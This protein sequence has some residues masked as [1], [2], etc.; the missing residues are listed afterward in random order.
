MK[1]VA[2]FGNVGGGK[3]TLARRLADLTGVPL[4]PVDM[5]QIRPGGEYV[6]HEEYL[7]VHADI[8][9]RDSWIIE[10]YGDSASAWQRF[11]AADTL[12][13]I[14]L[15]VALHVWWAT[16]RFFK[17]IL[18][19]PEGWPENSPMWRFTQMSY[20]VIGR[21]HRDLTPKYRRLV[22]EEAQSKEVHH[23]RSAAQMRSFLEHVEQMKKPAG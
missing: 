19:D 12:V 15:P 10:G 2:V 6:P 1:R 8:L 22:A 14:D 17:G 9:R 16:K 18:I 7:K 11:A 3:S 20:R 23:L 5:I 21:W 13:Y 4:Y